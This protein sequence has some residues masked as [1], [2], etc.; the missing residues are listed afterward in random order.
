MTTLV[1]GATGFVGSHVVRQLVASGENVRVLVR[2][3]SNVRLL[4]G[5]PAERVEGGV[6]RSRDARRAARVPC[7]G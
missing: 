6:D 3:A 7:G 2:A 1:T 5:I 4:E